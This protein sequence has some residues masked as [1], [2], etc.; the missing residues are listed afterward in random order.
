MDRQLSRSSNTIKA[1]RAVAQL[2]VLKFDPAR[3][4]RRTCRERDPINQIGGY[5]NV[6]FGPA[7]LFP[8][9]R[10]CRSN[11]YCNRFRIALCKEPVAICRSTRPCCPK[12]LAAGNVGNVFSRKPWLRHFFEI[13]VVSRHL[14]LRLGRLAGTKPIPCADWHTTRLKVLVG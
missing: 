5:L 8:P 14:L 10:A 6:V 3:I 4:I 2:S 12:R 13:P 11:Q 1:N 9:T 7:G